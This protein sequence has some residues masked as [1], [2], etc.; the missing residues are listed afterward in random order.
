MALLKPP[1]PGQGR[2]IPRSL[3]QGVWIVRDLM[4]LFTDKPATGEPPDRTRI[5][6]RGLVPLPIGRNA[7]AFDAATLADGLGISID[8]LLKENAAGRLWVNNKALPPQPGHARIM[9]FRI[10]VG[11][12]RFEFTNAIIDDVGRA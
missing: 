12:R 9:R 11:D 3:G 2:P 1:Y 10:G 7:I 8:E 5:E 6:I 4:I